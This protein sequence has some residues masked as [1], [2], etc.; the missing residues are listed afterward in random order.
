MRG[1]KDRNRMR[2]RGKGQ[3]TVRYGGRV[4]DRERERVVER[5]GERE[6]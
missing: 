2:D 3:E 5:G 6:R 1:G 4:I